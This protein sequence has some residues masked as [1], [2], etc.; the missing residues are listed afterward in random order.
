MTAQGPVPLTPALYKGQVYRKASQNTHT[1]LINSFY[2]C[3]RGLILTKFGRGITLLTLKKRKLKF[4][5]LTDSFPLPVNKAKGK[6]KIQ[7]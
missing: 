5:K 3:A 6:S 2:L 7:T 1:L 4:R